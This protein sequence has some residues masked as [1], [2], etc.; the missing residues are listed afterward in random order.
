[1][2][3]PRKWI[4]A[5]NDRWGSCFFA[6]IANWDLIHG[7]VP[8]SDVE[9]ESAA[10][11][12]EGWSARD[13]STDRGENMEDGFRY[14]MAHGWPGDPLLRVVSWRPIATDEIA[15]TVQLHKCAPAWV[16]LPDVPDD[17][18]PFGEAT[19]SLEPVKAHALLLIEADDAHLT[20]V[21][22][23]EVWLVPWAWWIKFGRQAYDVVHP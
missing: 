1:M 3:L 9:I 13:P 14:L 4:L 7:G 8:M 21:S 19:L 10:R 15:A 16:M 2:I 22:W 5:E 18:D 17:D 6:M 11:A 20:V 23:G 12:M